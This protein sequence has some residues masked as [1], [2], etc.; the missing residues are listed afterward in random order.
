MPN[1]SF[2]GFTAFAAR[3]ANVR[4]D[5]R[6]TS[7][8]TGCIRRAAPG[9]GRR[10]LSARS[11]GCR[12]QRERP[13]HVHLHAALYSSG[14][15]T[16]ARSRRAP[17][18]PTSCW[19]CRSRRHC[20]SAAPR[21]LRST[22]STCILEDN[23]QK[24]AK[25]TFNL[26]L[27][28]ELAMPYM[29]VDGQ[30]A[31]L[32]AAPNFSAVAPVLPGAVGPFTG[33]FPAGLLNADKNNVAPAPWMSRTASRRATILRGG[34]SITYNSGSYASIAREL[35]GQP[36]FADT[37]TVTGD[38]AAPLTLAQALLVVEF[39][40]DE[41]LGRRPGLR[42]RDDS[43]LERRRS[44][45]N[46]S[47]NWTL[48]RGVH[49][50][51]GNRSRHASR[52]RAVAP[53]GVLIPGVRALHVGILGRALADERRKLP[54][55]AASCWRI[56]RRASPTRSRN[57]WTTPPRSAPAAPSSRRTTRIWRGVRAVELRPASQLSGICYVEL[58]FGPDR[59]WLKNGGLLAVAVRRVVGAVQR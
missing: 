46:L 51:Q 29:E 48:D 42:A 13:R 17:T 57:R 12:D 50:H 37:E 1:L 8:Y 10:R 43:D 44:P 41:Q 47:Q 25:L 45:R 53:D 28:Y 16:V 18:S 49:R 24:S 9:A 21:S 26:G 31:N 58:P 59:R 33:A 30:M 22:P 32:D 19:G 38:E 54:D 39:E 3:L 34:Y 23:W 14:G 55:P 40:H 35:V 56:Q 6:L 4:T 36:P 2:S 15:A 52:A 20:R 5:D 27:R 7:G 11:V